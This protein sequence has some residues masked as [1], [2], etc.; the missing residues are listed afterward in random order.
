M[1]DRVIVGVVAL[2][3]TTIGFGEI[4]FCFAKKLPRKKEMIATAIIKTILFLLTHLTIQGVNNEKTK[5]GY[6]KG[7]RETQQI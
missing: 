3:L 5:S 7:N 6:G 4:L 2:S 1:G